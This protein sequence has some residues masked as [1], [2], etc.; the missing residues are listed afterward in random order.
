MIEHLAISGGSIKGFTFYGI[1]KELHKRQ[2]WKLENI[3]SIHCVSI[4][5]F[6]SVCCMLGYS[7]DILDDYLIKRPWEK[8]F[9]FQFGFMFQI[10]EK[11]GMFDIKEIKQMLYPLLRGANLAE[12]ITLREFYEINGVDLFI[13]ATELSQMKMCVFN[14]KTHP[15]WKLVDVIYCSCCLPIVFSPFRVQSL[16]PPHTTHPVAPSPLMD[17]EM[18][19]NTANATHTHTDTHTPTYNTIYPITPP[20]P[21]AIPP[22]PTDDN[23]DEWY[24][25]GGIFTNYPLPFLL[26]DNPDIDETTVLGIRACVHTKMTEKM[27]LFDFLGILI[28]FLLLCINKNAHNGD[29]G[30]DI[31]A[32]TNEIEV[33]NFDC[34][35]IIM[36]IYETANSTEMRKTMIMDGERIAQEF[37][38]SH[39]NNGDCDINCGV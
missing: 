3:K 8:V 22:P 19:M 13:Y 6:V 27:S 16:V 35:D 29:K 23:N 21:S 33:A 12:D 1:L 25:D 15:D 9:S 10:I 24:I 28:F 2:Y 32:I 31:T 17:I 20:Q 4:G 37:L 34:T 7:W 38:I 26:R 39:S 18:N 5:S 30:A 14:H 36:K 11:R